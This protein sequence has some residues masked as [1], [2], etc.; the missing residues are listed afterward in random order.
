[1]EKKWSGKELE[2]VHELVTELAKEAAHAGKIAASLTNLCEKH[3]GN[4][5]SE[6]FI[7]KLREVKPETRAAIGNK[8]Q[9]VALEIES[10]E[11]TKLV[12]AVLN[13][14]AELAKS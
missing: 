4:D 13:A 3:K 5:L 7:S 10:A 1:M 11:A 2:K 12:T 9:W 8:L 14:V 6:L